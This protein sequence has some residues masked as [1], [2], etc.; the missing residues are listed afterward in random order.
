M[1]TNLFKPHYCWNSAK[2]GVKHQ[3]LNHEVCF[4]KF[5]IGMVFLKF[6]QIQHRQT[7]PVHISNRD[8]HI[9]SKK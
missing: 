5:I 6:D 3:S 9:L 7:Q 8:I 2:D 4:F 1:K